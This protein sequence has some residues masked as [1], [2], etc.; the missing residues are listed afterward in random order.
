MYTEWQ[1]QETG[2]RLLQQSFVPLFERTR[3]FRTYG[4][5]IMP[6][7]LQTRAYAEALLRSI[8]DF[9]G[10]PDDAAEAAVARVARTNRV[11]YEGDHRFVFLVE[12]AALRQAVGD[13]AAMVEQ[14]EYLL[15]AMELPNVSLGVVPF[16]AGR[17]IRMM[18]TF[19]LF[20][21]GAALVELLTGRVDLDGEAAAGRYLAVFAQLER[22]AVYGDDARAVIRGAASALGG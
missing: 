1:H 8:R 5:T 14:L 16:G 2:L 7:L 10:G 4:S 17:G 22:L 21:E 3:V 15:A 20:D 18:E 19:T 11:L 12:E 13:G 6:G 9:A